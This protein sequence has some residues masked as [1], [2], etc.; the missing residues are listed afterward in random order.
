[1]TIEEFSYCNE[2]MLSPND[3]TLS[4]KLINAPSPPAWQCKLEKKLI[5]TLITFDRKFPQAQFSSQHKNRIM[6]LSSEEYQE[7]KD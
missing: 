7:S 3:I 5:L 6:V 2:F 4:V 1:M